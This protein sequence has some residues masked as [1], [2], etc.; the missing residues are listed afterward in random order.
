MKKKIL[1]VLGTRPE[2]IRLSC[3]LKTLDKYFNHEIVNTNQNFSK[4]LNLDF[5]KD[6][7]I[8]KPKYSM[9]N[10]KS[11]DPI[12]FI[13]MGLIFID[14]ILEN[15]KPDAILILGDTNTSLA[16][17]AAKRK[18]IPIFHLEAGN[19]CFDQRV[20]EEINRKIVD[21]IAD[22]NLTY[23]TYAEN[24]LLREGLP[25][26]LIIKVGSPLKEVYQYYENKINK[27]KIVEKL[28]LNKVKYV[29]ASIHREE[30]LTNKKVLDDILKSINIFS[31]EKKFRIIFSTHPRTL[32]KLKKQKNKYKNI[33]FYKSFGFMDYIKLLKSSSLVISDSGSITEE[34]SILNL[35]SIN[36]RSSHERQEG[37]EKGICIMSG[38]KQQEILQSLNLALSRNL[39]EC[40]LK[41]SDYHE[42]NVS[43]KIVNII[44]SYIP[45]INKKIWSKS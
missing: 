36:L 18:K 34:T 45:Y 21:H 19:R 35:R 8:R 6:L 12:K 14:K 40:D 39:S 42:K 15:E 2:I 25:R 28:K 44:Q 23:S 7:E 33:E 38:L 1:T 24:N 4:N 30:N 13:S 32:E 37:M 41:L 10:N 43:N 17:I 20:P 27:S 3:I 26:D 16:S 11:K 9:R 22:L 5:F 29:V 31:K